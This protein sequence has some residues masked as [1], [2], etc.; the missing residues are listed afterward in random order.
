MFSLLL[1]RLNSSAIELCL[2]TGI[3]GSSSRKMKRKKKE[4]KTSVSGKNLS[5]ADRIGKYQVTLLEIYN[6]MTATVCNKVRET[7][8]ESHKVSEA[9][10]GPG[11]A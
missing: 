3:P 8:M 11:V 6:K 10:M 1:K 2:F 4:K 5:P 9:F 7:C